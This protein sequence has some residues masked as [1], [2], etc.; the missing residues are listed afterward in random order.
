MSAD[1]ERLLAA[2]Y[3]RD[4]CEPDQRIRCERNVGRLINDA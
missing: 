4:H 1:L 3:E 2:L